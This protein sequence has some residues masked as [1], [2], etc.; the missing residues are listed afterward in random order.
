MSLDRSYDAACNERSAI[1]NADDDPLAGSDSG[2]ANARAEGVCSMRRREFAGRPNAGV[3]RGHSRIAI[4][5]E[6]CRVPIRNKE[7]CKQST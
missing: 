6:G 2:H 5:G 1:I 4:T 7:Q 3:E